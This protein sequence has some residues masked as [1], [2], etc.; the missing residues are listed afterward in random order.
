MWGDASLWFYYIIIFH[1]IWKNFG[2]CFLKFFYP[3]LPLLSFWDSHYA[4]INMSD[5]SLRVC[6]F[7]FIYFSFYFSDWIIPSNLSSSSLILPSVILNLLLKLVNLKIF[8]FEAFNY[9]LS[10]W[11]FFKIIAILLLIFS[12]QWVITIIL[13]LNFLNMVPF[14]LFLDIF[15]IDVF[16][17]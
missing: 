16:K 11:F 6:S 13:F 12:I 4:Y 10:T 2:Y 17:F 1:Q 15:I 3:F 5:D 7:L 8:I 9:R 14:S